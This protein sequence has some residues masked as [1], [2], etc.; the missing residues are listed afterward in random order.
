MLDFAA[1]TDVGHRAGE[2]EDSIGW[3]VE[4]KI[5]LVADGMGGHAAGSTASTVAR[6]SL[7]AADPS[8]TTATQLVEAHEAIVAAA[9]ENSERA[10][11]GSTVVVARVAGSTAEISW[12]GDS[13]AYLW[14]G[15]ELRQLTRDHSFIEVLRAQGILTEEQLRADPRSNLVTQTLGLGDPQPSVISE[16][17][18][19]GDWILLCSDG[20]NDEVEDAQIAAILA[21]SSDVASAVDELVRV[22]LNNGGRDNTSVIIVEFKGRRGLGFLWRLL[23]SRWLPLIIGAIL[24]VI[25][26]LVLWVSH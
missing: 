2:N 4:K 17:L 12:V 11:M 16:S 20:L 18:R 3:D 15:G 10:G 25:F 9:A 7:L 19:F 5:W 1:K 14:R 24:A 26:A 8:K 13:R 21:G 22:A 23:D 6:R